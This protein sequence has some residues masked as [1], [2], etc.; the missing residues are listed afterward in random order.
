MSNGKVMIIHV[1][2]GLIKRNYYIKANNFP[3]PAHSKNKIEVALDLACMKTTVDE[4]DVDEL[5]K[6]SSSLDSLKSKADQIDSDRLATVPIDLK[7]QMMYK[8]MVMILKKMHMTNWLKN[9]MSLILVNLLTK[10]II[11]LR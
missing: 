11:M 5:Q 4:L 1:I 3:E 10:Q 9:L 2:V 6:I 7:N 8:M